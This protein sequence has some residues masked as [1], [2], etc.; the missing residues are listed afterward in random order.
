MACVCGMAW[1]NKDLGCNMKQFTLF[2]VAVCGL[3]V[4]PAMATDASKF[5]SDWGASMKKCPTH[6]FTSS[7]GCLSNCSGKSNGKNMMVARAVN[8][9]GAKF[10]LTYVNSLRNNSSQKPWTEYHQGVGLNDSSCVWLCKPGWGG[11]ECNTSTSSGTLSS[12][13]DNTTVKKSTY[14]GKS[15]ACTD[16]ASKN[17]TCSTSSVESSVSFLV[18]SDKYDC[19]NNPFGGSEKT[20]NYK[21]EHDVVLAI[22]GWTTSGH[23]AFVQPTVVWA[24]CQK[25]KNDGNCKVAIAPQSSKT[26]LCKD[27]YKPNS[28][29]TD[30]EAIN[31]YVCQGIKDCS[32][33]SV[34]RFK[35][36][37]YKTVVVN[38]NG[39]S[40]T[41]YR[42]A[43]ANYGFS[44][45]PISNSTCR[46]CTG[47]Y[48]KVSDTNGQCVEDTAARAAA[49]AAA[50]AAEE[51]AKKA[52]EEAAAKAAAEAA[53]KAAE[54]A[55]AKAQA[56]AEAAAKAAA[57]AAAKA[58]EEAAA[59][60]Q[61]EAEAAAKAA[62]EAAK[63]AAEEA[64][65]KAAEEA[66]TETAYTGETV[67]T[68]VQTVVTTDDA[69]N[70]VTTY[71]IGKAEM[72]LCWR[73][74]SSPKDYKECVHQVVDG[75]IK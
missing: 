5:A 54:E 18:K 52:A 40:C 38:Q 35:G 21:M 39:G 4:M 64:A 44:G 37:S 56:E 20:A 19:S 61:A 16:S 7:N 26:L 59:K 71:L 11:D 69:G 58:A 32:G 51:A 1:L 24:W 70:T 12:T 60:A 53:A 68:Q 45:D 3:V 29:K 57:E 23:G 63:K 66:N 74:D 49:E 13:C 67:E 8:S 33:W 42:C 50:K 75:R 17:V 27:G 34:S 48:E 31:G 15:N 10:C 65:K 41:Q 36:S 14:D 55:A 22:T 28:G 46:A 9:H 73:K 43:T 6:N 62:E 30:C 25:N 2:C 72:Q 47:Q